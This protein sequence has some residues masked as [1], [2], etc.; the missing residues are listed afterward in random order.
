MSQHLPALPVLLPL[1]AGALLLLFSSGSIANKRRVNLLATLAL[2]PVSLILLAGTA[3]GDITVYALGNW[4]PPFGIVL[5]VDRFSALMLALTSSLAIPVLLYANR[6]DDRAGTNFHALFQFQLLGI[7]GAFLTGDLFNLFVFFEILLIASYAL[8][9]FGGGRLR[10][11]AGLHYVVLNL[12]GSA[13]FLIAVGILY[14]ITG[15]LNMADLARAVSTLPASDVAL[16]HAAGLLLLLV[17]ALKAAMLPVGFWLPAAYAHTS[18]PVAALFAIMTKVGLYAILRVHFLVFG[19]QAGALAGLGSTLLWAAGLATLAIG[20]IGAFGASHL[21]GVLAW[22]VLVSV[23]TLLAGAAAGSLDALTATL[24]YLLHSTWIAAAMFLLAGVISERRGSDLLRQG[25]RLADNALGIAFFAGA[26]ALVGLP[27]LSGFIG[28]LLLLRA[29][30]IEGG[31]IW[32]WVL[33]L[34]A[35]LLA[36]LALSRAGSSLFWRGEA[37]TDSGPSHGGQLA[38]A[39]LL[40]A[41]APLLA[42]GT[43]PVLDFLQATANGILQ[44]GIYIEAVL[45]GIREAGP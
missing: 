2:L 25:P 42:L 40:L 13:L 31:G 39:W 10:T 15:T 30:G 9:L 32:L 7:N 17:F 37:N 33:L 19:E 36:L 41:G 28:K 22:L 43:E 24:Y 27:P 35:G 29:V 21:R 45:G 5:V 14:G 4:Q 34:A 8:L 16:V 20:A 44:P 18:A 3:A 23:G 38:S 6:G 12:T 11:A 1:L 26:V